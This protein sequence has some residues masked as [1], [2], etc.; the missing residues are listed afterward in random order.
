MANKSK[1]KRDSIPAHQAYFWTKRW[2]DGEKEASRD[3][4]SGRVR[5]H[6]SLEKL[7][8]HLERRRKT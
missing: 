3:I 1:Q 2:Q 7:F 5:K 4:Q 6:D 8:S